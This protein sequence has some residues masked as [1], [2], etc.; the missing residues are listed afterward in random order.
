MYKTFQQRLGEDGFITTPN[1]KPYFVRMTNK[2]VSNSIKSKDDFDTNADSSA[3][4]RS[5]VADLGTQLQGILDKTSYDDSTYSNVTKLT[6]KDTS[7]FFTQYMETKSGGLT[8]LEG[9][10]HTTYKGYK[11]YNS[12]DVLKT[13]SEFVNEY[14]KSYKFADVA[15]KKYFDDNISG[16][17]AN[18][19]VQAKR[20]RLRMK[21]FLYPKSMTELKMTELIIAFHR[22]HFQTKQMFSW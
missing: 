14:K 16:K 22:N 18:D 10:D 5:A 19:A 13:P 1:L 8:K 9:D 21:I 20:K 11:L 17:Y 6:S 7:P 12:K 4:V 3:T 2:S 15:N